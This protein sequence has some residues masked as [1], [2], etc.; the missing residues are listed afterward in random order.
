MVPAPDIAVV[1]PGGTGDITLVV[2]VVK[3]HWVFADMLDR[4]RRYN[5]MTVPL[6]WVFE[7]LSPMGASITEF[8]PAAGGWLVA[9]RRTD[10]VFTTDDP[11]PVFVDLPR[12]AVRWPETFEYIA[13][14]GR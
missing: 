6:Y 2:D 9:R 4:F 7:V 14:R 8:R 10:E 1:G 5:G 3:G 13:P 12:M 11:F